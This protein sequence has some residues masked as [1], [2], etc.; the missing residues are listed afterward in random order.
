M[1]LVRLSFFRGLDDGPSLAVPARLPRSCLTC[2]AA[3]LACWS[4]LSAFKSFAWAE[5]RRE[6]G[7]FALLVRGGG[8]PEAGLSNPL[9]RWSWLLE[10]RGFRWRGDGGGAL[11]GLRGG[12]PH[13]EG[14]S[15]RGNPCPTV[16]GIDKATAQL[17]LV[18]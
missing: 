16:F 18:K 1:L 14:P 15:R 11:G 17:Q 9:T 10:R 3:A 13:S 7:V 6:R 8:P 5:R 2:C 12:A 4:F